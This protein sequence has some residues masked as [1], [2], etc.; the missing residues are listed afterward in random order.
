MRFR[1]KIT[2]AII[3]VKS[4]LKGPWEKIGGGAKPAATISEPEKAEPLAP[5]DA[6]PVKKKPGRKPKK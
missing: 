6:E 1:N 3:D 2:G 5:V 4:E